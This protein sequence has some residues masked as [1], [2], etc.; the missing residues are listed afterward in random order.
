M[1]QRRLEG[2]RGLHHHCRGD[3]AAERRRRPR[4]GRPR[5]RG[6][7]P[8]ARRRMMLGQGEGQGSRTTSTARPTVD[9]PGRR[10]RDRRASPSLGNVDEEGQGRVDAPLSDNDGRLFKKLAVETCSSSRLP[11]SRLAALHPR[12]TAKVLVYERRGQAT[13]SLAPSTPTRRRRTDKSPAAGHLLLPPDV[14]SAD[15][16]RT[17]PTPSARPALAGGVAVRPGRPLRAQGEGRSRSGGQ[18]SPH[19]ARAGR[20]PRRRSRQGQDQVQ[21]GER[22]QD[23]RWSSQPRKK[24]K[25]LAAACSAG[26]SRWASPA[27]DPRRLTASRSKVAFKAG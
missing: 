10:D 16:R 18:Y 23:R 27:G 14:A 4:P 3:R 8:P 15:R 26:T 22:R 2:S 11:A 13:S 17:W 25:T 12:S 20:T 7:I 9:L 19:A 6:R 21:G 24:G 1:S 5:S